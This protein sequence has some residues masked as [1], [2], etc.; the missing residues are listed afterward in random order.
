MLFIYSFI[1]AELRRNVPVTGD[2]VGCGGQP[3]VRED[4]ADG[5]RRCASVCRGRQP[6]GQID[7]PGHSDADVP[8]SA[9]RERPAARLPAAAQL[10]L[11][12]GRGAARHVRVRSAQRSVRRP[13]RGAV[14]RGQAVRGRGVPGQAPPGPVLPVAPMQFQDQVRPA[15]RPTRRPGKC[16]EPRTT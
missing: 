8:L 5:R 4:V 16:S 9:G 1:L 12:H 15:G 13:V 7:Q 6:D 10:R 14:H 2:P 3:A 11:V